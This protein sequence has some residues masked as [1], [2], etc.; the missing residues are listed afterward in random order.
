[1][2]PLRDFDEISFIE[3]HPLHTSKR[4]NVLADEIKV[5]FRAFS[6]EFSLDLEVFDVFDQNAK[7]LFSFSLIYLQ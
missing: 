2:K 5:Q 4:E 6:Q 3:I 1:V 7:V